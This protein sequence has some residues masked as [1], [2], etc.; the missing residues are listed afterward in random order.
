[1]KA[2]FKFCIL[3]TVSC[4][5]NVRSSC[6]PEG[7]HRAT[8]SVSHMGVRPVTVEVIDQDCKADKSLLM[9]RTH[10]FIMHVQVPRSTQATGA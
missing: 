9:P 1:M 3:Y 8:V 2:C 5:H 10:G 6:A 7:M 4:C